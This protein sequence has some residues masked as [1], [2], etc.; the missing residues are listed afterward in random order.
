MFGP[1]EEDAAIR[2]AEHEHGRQGTSDPRQD[3][4]HRRSGLRPRAVIDRVLQQ[5]RINFILTNRIPRRLMTRLMGWF[6]EIEHPLVRDLSIGAWKFF[7][8]DPQL[9]E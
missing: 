1:A 8:G 2:K 9:H 4:R 5:E 7:A 6:S 3:Y